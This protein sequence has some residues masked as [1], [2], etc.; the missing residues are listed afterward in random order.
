M[1]EKNIEKQAV[2]VRIRKCCS[3]GNLKEFNNSRGKICK[4]C[5]IEK[6]CKSCGLTKSVDNF[7][8]G[9]YCNPCNS[10]K[11]LEDYYSNMEDNRKSHA[12]SAKNRRKK[13]NLKNPHYPFVKKECLQCFQIV[14][15]RPRAKICDPCFNKNI[16]DKLMICI[17]CNRQSNETRFSNTSFCTDCDNKIHYERRK[18]I[19]NGEWNFVF[20]EKTPT[21]EMNGKYFKFCDFCKN[22]KPEI[23]FKDYGSQCEACRKK[24]ALD[25]KKNKRGTDYIFNLKEQIS[26]GIYN[27]L[28]NNNSSKNNNSCWMFLNYTPQTLYNHIEI[29]FSHPGNLNPFDGSV[30]MTW[31]NWGVYRV[32]TWD[33]N[34]VSTWTW[35]IDHIIPHSKF[36]Y[37]TMEDDEFKQCWTLDNLRPYNAKKNLLDGVNRTRHNK[38]KE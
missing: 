7:R 15:F 32:E 8:N 37:K 38:D 4:E 6:K 18:A 36:N 17:M 10:A 11:N 22:N 29:L 20:K 19:E 27:G 25:W 21:I 14:V 31:E 5:S 16:S 26:K 12:I 34:D 30:W 23:E 3:C 28:K 24:I 2:E 35:Q 9:N 33:D 1:T 13:E